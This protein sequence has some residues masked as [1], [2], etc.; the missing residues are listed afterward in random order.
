MTLEQY[1][2]EY[3]RF[4][5][6]TRSFNDALDILF[7]NAQIRVNGLIAART[8]EARANFR[9]DSAAPLLACHSSQNSNFHEV[10]KNL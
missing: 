10:M 9:R 5:F 4:L 8:L 7:R 3:A 6:R 1:R 2:V